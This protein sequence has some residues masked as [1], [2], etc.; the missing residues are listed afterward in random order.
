M[1]KYTY[2][3]LIIDP[4]KEGIESLIGKEVYFHNN[5][6]LCLENAN[7]KSI[8]NLGILVE[9]FK[10]SIVPF[11]IEQKCGTCAYTCAHA[12]IIEK[13]EEP[14]PEYALFKN[15]EEFLDAYYR[16]ETKKLDG[17]YRYLATRGIWI[18][19]K[20]TY[21]SYYMV[22]EIWDDGVIIGDS[23]INTTQVSSDRYFTANDITSWEELFNKYTFLDGSLCGKEVE[24]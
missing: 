16:N 23:K 3:N 6:S 21:T 11:R 9:I 12:C 17:I 2:S 13:K 8:S 22:T 1:D 7:E 5:P 10:N 4:T 18:K 14:K 24:E 20:G 19:G 15:A